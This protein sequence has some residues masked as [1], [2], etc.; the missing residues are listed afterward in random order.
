MNS[1]MNS[2]DNVLAIGDRLELF[3]DD[4]LIERLEG[5]KLLLHKPAP[6]PLPQSP[7]TGSYMTV[8]KDGDL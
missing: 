1:A 2:D 5:A 4:Y 3:V 8:I 7:F 6:M